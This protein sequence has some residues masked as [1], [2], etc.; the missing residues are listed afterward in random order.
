MNKL[1]LAHKM[2]LVVCLPL[3]AL[4]FFSGRY[5]YERYQVEQ[6]MSQAQAALYVVREAAQL[7]IGVG[8]AQLGLPHLVAFTACSNLRSQALM[9]R[10]GMVYQGEFDHPALAHTSRLCR[11]VWYRLDA[12]RHLPQHDHAPAGASQ[13]GAWYRAWPSPTAITG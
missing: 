6:E 9:Q 8:F 2:L 11:H 10:L 13:T 5:V 4:L 1:G 7:A 3:L 12:P